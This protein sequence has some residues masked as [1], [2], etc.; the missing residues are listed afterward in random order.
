MWTVWIPRRKGCTLEEVEA[1]LD[2][3]T[4]VTKLVQVPIGSM[5]VLMTDQ[6]TEDE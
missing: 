3:G 4:T 5:P 6:I 2:D 1:I